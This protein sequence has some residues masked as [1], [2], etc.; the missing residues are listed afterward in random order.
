MTFKCA[1]LEGVWIPQDITYEGKTHNC[2][3]CVLASDHSKVLVKINPK[4]YRP[5]EVELLLGNSTKA[6]EKL[7]WNPNTTFDHLIDDM[8][9]CDLELARKEYDSRPN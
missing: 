2:E 4:F 3:C 6:K 9:G 8:V 5:A 1:G 7:N